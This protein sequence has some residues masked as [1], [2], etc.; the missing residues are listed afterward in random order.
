MK[1]GEHLTKYGT[2]YSAQSCKE[3]HV[4]ARTR[5]HR[6]KDVATDYSEITNKRGES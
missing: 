1:L 5:T 4:C 6:T 3:K 2:L